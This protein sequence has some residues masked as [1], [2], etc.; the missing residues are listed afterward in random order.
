MLHAFT[1][2]V[3]Q[4]QGRALVPLLHEWNRLRLVY[5]T[6]S[7]ILTDKEGVP[8]QSLYLTMLRCLL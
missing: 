7:S 3:P 2:G 4:A 1:L 6:T 8:A 5:E